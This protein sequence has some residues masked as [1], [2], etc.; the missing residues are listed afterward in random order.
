M[1]AFDA[2]G[3]PNP[4]NDPAPLFAMVMNAAIRGTVAMGGAIAQKVMDAGQAIQ[5]AASS[6]AAKVSAHV[7]N[8]SHKPSD[9]PETVKDVKA[10]VRE[11]GIEAPALPQQAL[12]AA[13]NVG[14]AEAIEP[15][16]AEVT[17]QEAMGKQV[18]AASMERG[19]QNLA[20]G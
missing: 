19:H 14:R 16:M 3:L 6:T 8:M 10:R 17:L 13:R 18:V 20:L 12:D 9:T 11:Q 4:A 1:S 2:D 7:D 15:K 5:E